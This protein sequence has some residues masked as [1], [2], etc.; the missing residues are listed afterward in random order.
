[1]IAAPTQAVRVNGG[2]SRY[3]QLVGAVPLR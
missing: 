3:H 2:T 1:V